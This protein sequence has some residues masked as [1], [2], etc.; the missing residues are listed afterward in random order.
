LVS[1]TARRNG[2]SNALLFAWRKAY[3]EERHGAVAGFVPAIVAPEETASEPPMDE[4]RGP[5]GGAASELACPG[6]MVI[7]LGGAR[8]VIVGSDV[9]AAA[10]RRVLDVLERQHCGRRSQSEGR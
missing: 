9:N 6:Q 2:I 7:V 1:A 3:R 4:Q 8:R 10:L 5:L